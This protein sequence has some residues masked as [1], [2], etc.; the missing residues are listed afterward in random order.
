LTEF[1]PGLELSELYYREA[2]RPILDRDFPGLLHSAALIGYGSDVLG[3][4]TPVSTDHMWGPRLYLFL[5]ES[6]HAHLKQ[7]VNDALR[8]RLP[9]Q[10]R[11]YSTH[12]G[13]PDAIGV[14]LMVPGQAG[15]VDH[16][17]EICTVPSFFQDYLGY[18]VR[19][20]INL[21]DWLAFSEHRLLG[22]TAGKV[23][24]DD[25]DL[26]AV[27]RRLA[28]YP[29]Q[30]WRYLLA[31]QW[32]KISQEEPFVGRTGAVGDEL[33]SGVI[34]ARLV[35]ALMYLAFLLERRYAPY[36]KWFGTGFNHLAAAEELT[37]MLQSVLYARKWKD[38]EMALNQACEWAARRHNQLG[39]TAPMPEQ[40]SNFHGREYLVIQAE[41]FAEAIQASITD[42]E[43]KR[44][45]P[46]IG[47]VNQFVDST[48][49][50]E[51]VPLSK[52]LR[53]VYHPA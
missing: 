18:D 26:E 9:V 23:F 38:R 51:S 37:P 22:A 29:E 48:D 34:A 15:A 43:V 10:F 50:L 32:M 21:P 45:P 24:H 19:Q 16:L 46:Y 47:S 8:R 52:Q 27:R 35:H 12:F 31:A 33:G 20:E 13:S 2:V 14:R 3:F 40:V 39:I 1:I 41:M 11:G 44:L 5:E 28:Y 6:A 49:L 4:D 30:L 17:I 25:L 53:T 7:P 42:E 36:S